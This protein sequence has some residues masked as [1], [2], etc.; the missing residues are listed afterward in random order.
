MNTALSTHE[1]ANVQLLA[2]LIKK[3]NVTL[4]PRKRMAS[5]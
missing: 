1:D 5:E 3:I 2:E 4:T